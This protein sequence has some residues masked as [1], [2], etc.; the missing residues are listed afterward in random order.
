MLLVR[1]LLYPTQPV[2]ES[3]NFGGWP[4]GN[5][6]QRWPDYSYHLQPDGSVM[7]DDRQCATQFSNGQFDYRF[8]SFLNCVPTWT[9]IHHFCQWWYPAIP[10]KCTVALRLLKRWRKPQ[11]YIPRTKEYITRL[12]LNYVKRCWI[13]K[14]PFRCDG[15]LPVAAF[16]RAGTNCSTNVRGTGLWRHR[17]WN[18]KLPRILLGRLNY[19]LMDRYLNF[20]HAR[21]FFTFFTRNPLGLFPSAAFAWKIKEANHSSR[22]VVLF[23]L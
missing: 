1:P 18:R 13:N 23:R 17:L 10:R 14:K 8:H 9:C 21:W 16:R 12:Y 4:T 7:V 11:S 20:H 22:S 2:K 5:N 15:R 6:F 3:N 19:T